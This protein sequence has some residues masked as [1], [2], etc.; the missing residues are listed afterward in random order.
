MVFFCPK[1][2]RKV[3]I[4]PEYPNK[5][6]RIHCLKRLMKHVTKTEDPGLGLVAWI[7]HAGVRTSQHL[8]T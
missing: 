3:G 1:S 4:E 6:S 8:A 2:V 5:A 7:I